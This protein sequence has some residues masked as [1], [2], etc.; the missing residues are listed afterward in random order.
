MYRLHH[1]TERRKRSRSPD[2]VK[3]CS[4]YPPKHHR[5]SF[6]EV[7][8][9]QWSVHY[10]PAWQGYLTAWFR[11]SNILSRPKS[12]DFYLRS[13]FLVF[14][15]LS[16]CCCQAFFGFMKGLRNTRK[17]GSLSAIPNL[18]RCRSEKEWRRKSMTAKQFW[19]MARI[20]MG[21]LWCKHLT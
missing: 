6:K 8:M 15:L 18:D 5:V 7:A 14:M 16:Y 10:V 13:C 20:L 4:V 1:D 21:M 9:S 12:L 17:K 3:V 2:K 19:Q 11:N